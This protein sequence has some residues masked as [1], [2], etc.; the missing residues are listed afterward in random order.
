MNFIIELIL[1]LLLCEIIIYYSRK[2]ALDA[3]QPTSDDQKLKIILENIELTKDSDELKNVVKKECQLSPSHK[4]MIEIAG[5]E[6]DVQLRKKESHSFE[7]NEKATRKLWL[8]AFI[9]NIIV[10]AIIQLNEIAHDMTFES[11]FT[12][13]INN[14]PFIQLVLCMVTFRMT[15][16]C[17]YKN[18]GTGLLKLEIIKFCL[19]S[20]LIPFILEHL[21]ITP[22]F[23]ISIISSLVYIYSC[24][25][26][27]KVNTLATSK[28][29]LQALKKRMI[30]GLAY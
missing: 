21:T 30:D 27:I 3:L 20:A 25:S 4:K 12:D 14:Q 26:L 7:V 28:R 11:T 18:K 9:M 17:A 19:V 16:I 10:I 15:Y 13:L 22:S 8:A 2:R 24:Y 5:E 29:K 23:I 6:R 1:G